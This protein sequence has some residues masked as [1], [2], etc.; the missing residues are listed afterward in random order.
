MVYKIDGAAINTM[1]TSRSARITN[2]IIVDNRAG[3]SN[4]VSG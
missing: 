2:S 3:L 1:F 4:Q